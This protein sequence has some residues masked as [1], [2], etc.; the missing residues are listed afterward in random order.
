MVFTSVD[1]TDIVKRYLTRTEIT[2]EDVYIG[3]RKSINRRGGGL[4]PPEDP[5]DQINYL[6]ILYISNGATRVTTNLKNQRNMT[7]N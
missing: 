3:M 5:Q 6:Y 2:I 4:K 7:W 1:D